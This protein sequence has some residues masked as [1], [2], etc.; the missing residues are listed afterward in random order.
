M[1]K[2]NH[3]LR[4]WHKSIQ[5]LTVTTDSNHLVKFSDASKSDLCIKIFFTHGIDITDIQLFF[6]FFT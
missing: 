6:I 4:V 1:S 3:C 2:H 5:I